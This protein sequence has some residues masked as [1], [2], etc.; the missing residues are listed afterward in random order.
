MLYSRLS[1][2]YSKE[3]LGRLFNPLLEEGAFEEHINKNDRRRR[4]LVRTEQGKHL[5]DSAV[6]LFV[7]P[8]SAAYGTDTLLL[9]EN[10]WEQNGA[11]VDWSW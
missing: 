3:Q 6:D 2:I 8:L 9:L 11:K 7:S 1:T 4:Y 5:S 10:L